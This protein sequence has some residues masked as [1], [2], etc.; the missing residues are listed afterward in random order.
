MV[1]ATA[2]L[3]RP[4]RTRPGRKGPAN[5]D[6]RQMQR[7]FHSAE[8]MEMLDAS[9]CRCP[10]GPS[11]SL[12]LDP[13]GAAVVGRVGRT[14]VPARSNLA[15]WP[16]DAHPIHP[17]RRKAA[18][19]TYDMVTTHT[20]RRDTA[21]S[22]RIRRRILFGGTSHHVGGLAHAMPARCERVRSAAR[23][24]REPTKIW[25]S[26]RAHVGAPNST[27]G[28]S[29]TAYPGQY[30]PEC[31]QLRKCVRYGVCLYYKVCILVLVVAS[32]SYD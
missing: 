17:L 19:N 27:L 6:M 25:R 7:F 23:Q 31:R 3:R 16:V 4:K 22:D 8:S 32:P 10:V 13:S 1:N 21:D 12:L 29:S 18:E 20:E 11:L 14:C 9:R 30:A 28:S 15:N 24:A 5:W 26:A 2:F